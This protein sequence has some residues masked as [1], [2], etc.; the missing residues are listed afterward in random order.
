MIVRPCMRARVCVGVWALARELECACKHIISYKHVALDLVLLFS[1]FTFFDCYV[2]D[3]PKAVSYTH[4]DVYKRQGVNYGQQPRND[5]KIQGSE[6]AFLRG[7]KRCSKLVR[8]KNEPTRE[9]LQIFNLN[10]K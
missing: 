9:E 1:R 8:I 2:V 6:M 3:V 7:V 4:L 10:E 5:S